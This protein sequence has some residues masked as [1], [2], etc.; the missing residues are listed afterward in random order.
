MFNS[1][2]VVP[3]PRQSIMHYFDV[4]SR[5]MVAGNTDLDAATQKRNK[6]MQ[7]GLQLLTIEE[8]RENVAIIGTPEHCIQ[9]IRC[10]QQ[11]FHL[12]EL[13]CWFNS[14]GLMPHQTV[15]G[16]M[17]RFAAHTMPNFR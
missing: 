17:S 6:Q 7:T 5:R 10:L 2:A 13:I 12:R 11:E 8:V 9:C 4:F 3:L 14:G 16:L 15:L 1:L